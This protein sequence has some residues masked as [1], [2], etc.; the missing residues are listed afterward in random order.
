[1]AAVIETDRAGAEAFAARL[2]LSRADRDRLVYLV[3][4]GMS[5]TAGWTAADARRAIY[6]VGRDRF[7]DALLV[8]WAGDLSATA[9]AGASYGALID[10]TADFT[11]PAFPVGGADAA[12][13]GLKPGPEMGVA[14]AAVEAWWLE[15]DFTPDRDALL[16][17]L[18]AVIAGA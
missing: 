8:N 7:R 9:D 2:K 18:K 6:R 3:E 13:L 5:I 14:L 17:R 11:P 1:L 4:N 10:A 15:Q 12:K 16:A